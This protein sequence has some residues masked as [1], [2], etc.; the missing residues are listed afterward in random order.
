MNLRI[1]RNYALYGGIAAGN[2]ALGWPDG[3]ALSWRFWV[4]VTVAVFLAWKAL[5]S[6]GGK[7][8]PTPVEVVNPPEN[9]VNATEV[10]P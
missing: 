10:N 2:A 4:T 1:C 3:A 9:P 5:A 8:E 6:D 7:T